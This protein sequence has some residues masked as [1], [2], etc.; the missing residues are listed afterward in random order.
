MFKNKCIW[1][2][3]FRATVP[4]DTR[5]PSQSFAL[6]WGFV[7]DVLSKL[8]TSRHMHLNAK[9]NTLLYREDIAKKYS[10]NGLC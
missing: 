7:W 6:H 4:A 5:R 10:L 3:D 2:D 1:K 9:P 8:R